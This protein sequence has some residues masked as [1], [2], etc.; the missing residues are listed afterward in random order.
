MQSLLEVEQEDA[1]AQAICVR[2][3]DDSLSLIAGHSSEGVALTWH[4]CHI[5]SSPKRLANWILCAGSPENSGFLMPHTC[6]H[7]S[8]RWYSYLKKGVE[9]LMLS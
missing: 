4:A 7:L 9:A 6:E 8:F 5:T 1:S 3:E 2:E